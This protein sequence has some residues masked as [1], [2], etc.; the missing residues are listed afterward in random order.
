MR[1][2]GDRWLVVWLRTIGVVDL[3]AFVAMLQPVETLGQ[4][5]AWLG[6]G[7]FPEQVIA[8]YLT[9]TA[10]MLYGLCGLLLLFLSTDVD[11]YRP[12]IRFIAGCGMAAGM[13]LLGIDAVSQM[14]GWWLWV[15][16]PL[17]AAIWWSVWRLARPIPAERHE[18][19]LES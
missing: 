4:V 2:G 15:E 13:V 18:Q 11:R 6:L 16:G 7:T 9:R 3:L 1:T 10:S 8:A 14:P 19:S 12:V 5:H 17:C